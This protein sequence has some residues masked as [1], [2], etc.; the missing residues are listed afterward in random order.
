M[1]IIGSRLGDMSKRL[2]NPA[3]T[4]NTL[5]SL[6]NNPMTP[7]TSST[8][9]KSPRVLAACCAVAIRFSQPVYATAA[10]SS[11]NQITQER[12]PLI[13]LCVRPIV[14]AETMRKRNCGCSP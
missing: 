3:S 14:R 2:F 1:S 11:E 7:R 9:M 5:H 4:T 8:S 6:L 13:T 10:S 12:L